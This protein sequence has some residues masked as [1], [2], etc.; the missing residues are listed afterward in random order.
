MPAVRKVLLTPLNTPVAGGQ[1]SSNNSHPNEDVFDLVFDHY[2]NTGSTIAI[3][4]KLVKEALKVVLPY[5][6]AV[7]VKQVGWPYNESVILKNSRSS[8]S[9]YWWSS[10]EWRSIDQFLL[11][12]IGR[13]TID[14][15]KRLNLVLKP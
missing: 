8:N 2:N 5:D 13:L 11:P 7:K 6:I 3:G 1:V 10:K 4:P 12:D 9:V 14:K 15:E